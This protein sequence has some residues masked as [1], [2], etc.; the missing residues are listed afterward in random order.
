MLLEWLFHFKQNCCDSILID[1]IWIWNV[2]KYIYVIIFVQNSSIYI[3]KDKIN[4]NFL[5]AFYMKFSPCKKPRLRNKHFLFILHQ[6][7]GKIILHQ[8]TILQL[9][10]LHY[11]CGN[12]QITRRRIQ[13]NPCAGKQHGNQSPHT[14]VARFMNDIIQS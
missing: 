8:V 5:I 1:W 7:S 12:K 9:Y 2:S 4:I 13:I 3:L 10:I 6:K 14:Y 11:Q